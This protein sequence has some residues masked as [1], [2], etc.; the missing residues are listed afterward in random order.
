M[1]EYSNIS[2]EELMRKI[3]FN[4]SEMQRL[5]NQDPGYIEKN[6]T[7]IE[8]LFLTNTDYYLEAFK[9]KLN[10]P[11]ISFM[12]AIGTMLGYQIDNSLNGQKQNKLTK[13]GRVL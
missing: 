9:R 10:L 2:D 13:K 5:I 6:K 3:E 12:R 1:S 8:R 11:N 7:D 4:N